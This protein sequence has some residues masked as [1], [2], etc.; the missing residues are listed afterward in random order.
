[1]QHI[2]SDPTFQMACDPFRLIAEH[3]EIP[4]DLRDR[5][6]LGFGPGAILYRG[7]QAS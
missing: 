1:M 2:Y 6:I 5:L 4:N 7:D 3:L